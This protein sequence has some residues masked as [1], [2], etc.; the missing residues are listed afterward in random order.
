MKAEES[1]VM[2]PI[3][4]DSIFQGNPMLQAETIIDRVHT[5]M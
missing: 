4:E 1:S 3:S 2:S 5:E